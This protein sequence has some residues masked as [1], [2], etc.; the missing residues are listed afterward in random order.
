MYTVAA[1]L[2]RARFP[3]E[4][5]ARHAGFS[6]RCVVSYVDLVKQLASRE[7]HA[8]LV[9]A[10]ELREDALDRIALGAQRSGSALILCV[11]PRQASLCVLAAL[12]ARA[13]VE[14]IV[15]RHA[16]VSEIMD[17]LSR[18]PTLSLTA[19]VLHLVAP[20]VLELPTPIRGIALLALCAPNRLDVMLTSNHS[21]P[22]SSRTVSRALTRAGLASLSQ[23]RRGAGVAL[24]FDLMSDRSLRLSAIAQRAGMGSERSLCAAFRA[25]LGDSPRRS[26][27]KLA[28]SV[29]AERIASAVCG[30]TSAKAR[31]SGDTL[32]ASL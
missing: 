30:R 4:D 23:L 31:S 11:H 20:R 19:R 6:V 25:M 32:S 21:R 22:P 2:P 12:A 5:E 14:V 16:S 18:L 15:S 29:A 10:A 26:H 9:D 7:A 28:A 8:V 27:A 1:L 17:R 13:P 24:S 3:S